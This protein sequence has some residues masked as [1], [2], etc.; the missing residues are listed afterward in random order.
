M[1]SKLR[2]A[3]FKRFG[4]RLKQELRC[5]NREQSQDIPAG[6]H[7][8]S[9]RA[10]K[11]L[12]FYILINPHRYHDQF[13]IELAWSVNNTVPP[14][15]G[16]R[17]T[18]KP[19][20]GGL[21]FRISEL[22]NTNGKDHWWHLG[23][24][25]TLENFLSNVPDDAEEVKLARVND[26]VEDAVQKILTLSVPYFERI[27][28]EQGYH[29][30]LRDAFEVMGMGIFPKLERSVPGVD[31]LAVDG[32]GLAAEFFQSLESEGQASPF[33][34]LAGMFSVDPGEA[35]AFA[36]GEGIDVAPPPVNWHEAA[37]GLRAV[38]EALARLR[39]T[40]PGSATI[41]DLEHIETILEGATNAGARFYLTCDM[42]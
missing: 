5:F 23:T 42:P 14:S 31:S 4:Q 38:R 28:G 12:T 15:G 13:T 8:Y 19:K 39:E 32:K 25:Q 33:A 27:A 1:L 3:V 9:Y 26:Q 30:K 11:T 22:M 37:D 10:A 41:A 18:D 20:S 34:S 7:L 35:V 29:I 40:R 21:N 17:L 16:A 2:T 6:W 36:A 24:E